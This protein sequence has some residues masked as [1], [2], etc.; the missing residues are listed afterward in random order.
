MGDFNQHINDFTNVMFSSTFYP[1][2][3]RPTRISSTTAT[4]IDNIF[5][6]ILK[7][8]IVV[9]SYLQIYQII[10]PRF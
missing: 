10:Y 7:R 8:I 9:V 2:I 4:L 6:I 5:V 1:L 3:S